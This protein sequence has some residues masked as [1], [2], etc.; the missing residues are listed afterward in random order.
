MECTYGLVTLDEANKE[1]TDCDWQIKC[2]L[3]ISETEYGHCIQACADLDNY[4]K[5]ADLFRIVM[6]NHEDYHNLLNQYLN[7]YIQQNF[8]SWGT[9]TPDLNLNRYMMN[10]LSSVRSFLDYVEASVKRK[11]GKSSPNAEK[12]SKY[13]SEA[14]DK[15]FSYRFLY[16]FRNYA[17]HYGLPLTKI[18]FNAA[19]AD[20]DDTERSHYTLE[21]GIDRDELL[22]SS[23]EW[24]KVKQ[25]ISEQPAAISINK[26][27]DEMMTCLEEIHTYY[28]ADE[29][30]TL[31][32]SATYISSLLQKISSDFGE[33]H[34]YKL[35]SHSPDPVSGKVSMELQVIRTDLINDVFDEKFAILFERT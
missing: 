27:I 32:E 8:E 6:W 10:Y 25:E 14:Y 11:Y 4:W 12:F 26:H 31:R 33:L 21:V 24:G 16:R 34:L 7:S 5:N 17:Q 29:F 28:I 22:N 20:E 35:T 30:V 1:V 15:S 18:F 19:R 9:R 13:C 23:F 2:L 3:E